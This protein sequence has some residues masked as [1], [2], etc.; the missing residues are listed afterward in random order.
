MA[1]LGFAP[2]QKLTD[3][4]LSITTSFLWR[5]VLGCLP[6]PNSRQNSLSTQNQL[7]FLFCNS[8]CAHC[9]FRRGIPQSVRLPPAMFF[10][11]RWPIKCRLGPSA[12]R[13]TAGPRQRFESG[14]FLSAF[15][16]DAADGSTQVSQGM[17]HLSQTGTSAAKQHEVFAVCLAPTMQFLRPSEFVTTSISNHH[18]P[19]RGAHTNLL[20]L[21][22]ERNHQ[23][24][25]PN[26]ACSERHRSSSMSRSSLARALPVPSSLAPFR[27]CETR[28]Q[29][30]FSNFTQ[31]ATVSLHQPLLPSSMAP[32]DAGVNTKIPH[33]PEQKVSLLHPTTLWTP[34]VPRIPLLLWSRPRL[35]TDQSPVSDP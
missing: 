11:F 8:L 23:T 22:K 28:T 33:L 27:R 13:I 15:C 30:G 21:V 16:T 25:R 14:L 18:C 3:E 10:L 1:K 24:A 4:G 32:S 20:H 7:L 17:V 12:A 9:F 31:Q 29:Y 35:T 19:K 5:L 6:F 26:T 2:V 34:R